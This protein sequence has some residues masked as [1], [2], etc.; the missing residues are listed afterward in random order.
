MAILGCAQR[1]ED[2]STEG[3]HI[4][5]CSDSQ[6]ALRA[7]AVPAIHSR[8]LREC[9]EALGR[10]AERNRLLLLWV[11]G[12]TGIRS[13]GTADRLASLGARSGI[14]GT[15]PFVRIVRCKSKSII[16]EWVMKN[17]S[18]WWMATS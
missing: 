9:K 4:S 18:R 3:R 2:L 6:A 1:L 5:I 13:S 10:L 8:L 11:P 15:E 12:L 16:K 7:L 17:H 14:V